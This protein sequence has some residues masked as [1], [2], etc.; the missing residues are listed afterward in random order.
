VNIA[1]EEVLQFPL[2][3]PAEVHAGLRKMAKK[4][5][6]SVNKL[7]N[8]LLGSA[9]F[10]FKQWSARQDQRTTDVVSP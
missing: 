8:R 7:V 5:G 2:R 1:D 10:R 4:E 9:N 3:L 6:I